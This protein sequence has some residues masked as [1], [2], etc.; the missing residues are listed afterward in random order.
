MRP[1]FGNLIIRSPV[2]DALESL[3]ASDRML[4]FGCV[5]PAVRMAFPEPDFSRHTES[6]RIVDPSS[7]GSRKRK[8]EQ[9]TTYG[10]EN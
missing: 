9:E 10:T 3:G 7:K 1:A 2:E 4:S 5:A 8:S 6:L